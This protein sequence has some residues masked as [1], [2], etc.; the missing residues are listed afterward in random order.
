MSKI[1]PRL[2]RG[3]SHSPDRVQQIVEPFGFF[4]G[5]EVG[6][7]LEHHEFGTDAAYEPLNKRSAN[8]GVVLVARGR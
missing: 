6:R 1:P 4:A 7:V 8:A 2:M 5:G 3:P